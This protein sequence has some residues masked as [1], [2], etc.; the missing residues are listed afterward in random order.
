MKTPQLICLTLMVSLAAS[1][2]TTGNLVNICKGLL[3]NLYHPK[4]I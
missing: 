4:S 3:I 1:A 2:Q